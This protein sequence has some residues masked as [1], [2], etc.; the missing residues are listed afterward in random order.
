[1]TPINGRFNFLGSMNIPTTLGNVTISAASSGTTEIVVTTA[2]SINAIRTSPH[3]FLAGSSSTYNWGT[4]IIDTKSPIQYNVTSMSWSTDVLTLTHLAIPVLCIATQKVHITNS[5]N[6]AVVPNGVYSVVGATS[7]TTATTVTL[8][9]SGLDVS[10]ITA[11]VQPGIIETNAD[12]RGYYT[13]NS[14]TLGTISAAATAVYTPQIHSYTGQIFT[15]VVGTTASAMFGYISFDG[16]RGRAAI[17][18]GVPICIDQ[19]QASKYFFT[20]GATNDANIISFYR[21]ILHGG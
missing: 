14:P 17:P 4:R 3:V 20:T 12:N 9:G 10:G 5:S 16:G 8:V 21:P 1:M 13:I 11:R 19:L 2:T 6:T 7:T 15:T 18:Q